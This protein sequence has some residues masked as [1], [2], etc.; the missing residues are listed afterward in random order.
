MAHASRL[1]ILVSGRGTNMRALIEAQRAGALSCDVALVFSNVTSAP[2]LVLAGAAGVETCC[3]DHTRFPSREA[4]DEAVVAE[5]RARDVTHVALAGYRRLL[6]E[7]LL[8]PYEHR[9]VN[10]HPSLLPAFPG[11]DAQRQALDAGVKVT[12]CTIHFVDAGVDTGPI[13][14]QRALGIVEGDT[15]ESLS[16]R[17]LSVENT[18]Y[19]VAL[20][21]VLSGRA[22]VVA[23]PTGRLRVSV[24]PHW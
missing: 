9:V 22:R 2:A 10:V 21:A 11:L 6:S 13:I 3:T 16:E 1:A 5:L 14:S 12:G 20:E 19:P 4:F 17:L 15:V 23:G 8:R 18:L 24:D 7:R